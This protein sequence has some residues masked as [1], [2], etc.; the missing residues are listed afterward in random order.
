[1]MVI[2]VILLIAVCV[3][4][5]AV[6]GLKQELSDARTN[7]RLDRERARELDNTMRQWLDEERAKVTHL[8]E[9]LRPFSADAEAPR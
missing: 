5:I 3:L 1:M 2:V 4:L 8:R 9:R 6:I 7:W